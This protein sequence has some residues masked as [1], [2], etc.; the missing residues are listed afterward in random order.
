MI[1]KK[2]NASTNNAIAGMLN[3]MIPIQNING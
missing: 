2:A 1:F 3:A